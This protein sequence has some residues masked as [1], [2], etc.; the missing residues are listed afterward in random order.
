MAKKG[1]SICICLAHNYPAFDKAFV[2][3]LFTIQDD[4]H[5]WQKKKKRNDSLSMLI[6]G[7]YQ[8]DEM[9]NALVEDALYAKQDYL[10]FLD[11]DMNFPRDTVS[12]MIEVMEANPKAEAVT[13]IYTYK[14][15]P[16]LPQLFTKFDDKTGTF[17]VIGGKFPLNKP[18]EVGAAGAG[19]LMVKSDVFKREDG[20][21]FKFVYSGE[22]EK[23]PR[24]IG[25]DLFFFW[26][27]HPVT[28]ADP[29]IIC[30]HYD[31]RPVTIS[32]YIKYNKLKVKDNKI[33]I[34][35]KKLEE[36]KHKHSIG[37]MDAEAERKNQL[38]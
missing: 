2:L 13:G 36:I 17:H 37:K 4:F 11:T 22:N 18:F 16:Y 7:G 27:Y 34:T 19:I 25:E 23:L 28:I 12:R 30:G 9:R 33:N 38:G 1:K 6:R 29:A 26:K 15:P 32:N 10:L 14:R 8:L 35:S 21:Y 3:S 5:R 31:T 20:P 24:G